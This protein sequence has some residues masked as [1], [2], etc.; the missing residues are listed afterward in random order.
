MFK[1]FEKPERMSIF[2]ARRR[3]PNHEFVLINADTDNENVVTGDIYAVSDDSTEGLEQLRDLVSKLLNEGV[4]VSVDDTFD[5]D[6]I[7]EE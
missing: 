3:Y 7:C 1:I 2:E 6:I 5:S 4:E